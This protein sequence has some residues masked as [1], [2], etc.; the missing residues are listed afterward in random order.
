MSI[1]A[2]G[3]LHFSTAVNKPMNIF[4]DNWENHELKIIEDWKMQVKEDDIVL[5]VGDT[6]W[7]IKMD[8]AEQDLNKINELPGK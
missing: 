3:D 1:Y 7:A 2:I 6:S 4:G 8:E 5:I